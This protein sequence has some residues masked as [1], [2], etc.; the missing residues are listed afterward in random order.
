MTKQEIQKYFETINR[1]LEQKELKNAFDLLIL[2][3]SRLQNWQMQEELNEL[4][5]TYK[6]MILYLLQGIKDPEREKIYT[7]L[8]RSTYHL[9]DSVVFQMKTANNDSL[10]YE[11]L[12][13]VR[14]YIP[15]NT[16]QL[17]AAWEDIVGKIALT[18]LLDGETKIHNS[19]ELET[20]K[21][22]L[23]RKFF[24]AVWISSAWTAEEKDQWSDILNNSLDT[25]FL[26]GTLISAILLN[27]LETFDER[28]A[29]LLFE[30]ANSEIEEVRER[31]IVGI[32]LFLRK[33]N[34]RL[35]LYPG[36]TERLNLLAEKPA[37]IRQVR[38]VLLQFILSRETEKITRKIKDELLPEVM[39]M[40]PKLGE[41]FTLDDLMNDAGMDEK[42][43]E[44]Q[45]RL[46]KSGLQDKLQEFSEL[47]ME[48]ADVMHSSFIH[49]K[50]Y[51]FFNEPAN[52]FSLFSIPS[53]AIGDEELTNFANIL[54]NASML[55]NSDKYSFFLSV[56][57]MPKNHRTMLIKQFSVESE[58]VKEALK[59]DLQNSSQ[60]IDFRIRQYVQDLYRFYKLH[61]RRGDFEDIFEMKP[62]FY[63][64]PAI[65]QLIKDNES[66][67]II[68]EYYFNKNYFEEAADIYQML[69]KEEPNNDMLYQKRGYCLQM[70]N[71]LE[72]ALE[73]YQRAELLNSNHSWTIKKLAHCNRLL[74]NP[75]EALHYYK[76]AEQLH[77]DNLSIQLNIGHCYLELKDYDQAL[78][79]YFKVEYLTKNKEKA[80]RPI[81]WC[82]FLTGKFK[83]AN[84]YYL[85]IMENNPNASDYLN[86]GHV[87]LVTGKIQ[88]ALGLY[89]S[90]FEKSNQFPKD[91]INTFSQD[92]PELIKAG[93]KEEEI[94]YI[95]DSILY[96]LS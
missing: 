29:V 15:E 16:N 68:G 82:S 44:W 5:D 76:K 49:L 20:Q 93:I 61:P 34:N 17:I 80:W 96:E 45:T 13:S 22:N 74:K 11:K 78:K 86:A 43:P 73:C 52:W 14:F 8:L 56:S 35:L 40:S 65:N 58:S 60:T 63:K 30:A 66:L 95:V 75:E 32:V 18:E 94:P 62:E 39:K 77:P 79:Y 70:M 55:C 47:Q 19:K 37:F 21:E 9:S 25:V 91:F 42:N 72:E 88:D 59:E 4:Q 6:T 48:G 54:T 92:I 12:R 53:E 51:P 41:K 1:S 33:Y 36:I 23:L 81:A 87:Q 28:K 90:G 89:K 2:L 64:I 38:Q 83:Q 3:L 26:P 10:F 67:L 7:N 31:A 24:Y 71:R 27:L 85:K 50:N 57:Q 46:I 84:D 69:L